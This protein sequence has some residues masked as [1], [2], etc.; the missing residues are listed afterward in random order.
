MKRALAVSVMCVVLLMFVGIVSAWQPGDWI[1]KRFT[2]H[3]VGDP[4]GCVRSAPGLILQSPR[5]TY[6]PGGEYSLPVRLWNQDKARC[7]ASTL[8][9]EVSPPEGW[10]VEHQDAFS[11]VSSSQFTGTSISAPV[12]FTVPESTLPGKYF[13]IST[14]VNEVSGK[15]KSVRIALTVLPSLREISPEVAHPG[16]EVTLTGPGI[17]KSTKAVFQQFDSIRSVALPVRV[18]SEDSVVF[19]VPQK[20]GGVKTI[21]KGNFKVAARGKFGASNSLTIVVE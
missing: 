17:G 3:V 10:S 20:F 21:P 14:V 1:Q 6:Y 11:D 19:K 5:G 18:V 8:R 7:P 16:D 13:F 12:K 2:G 4:K 15:K 9:L